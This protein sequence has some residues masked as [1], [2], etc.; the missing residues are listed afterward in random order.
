MAPPGLAGGA[1]GKDGLDEY[2]QRGFFAGNT[3]D[4]VI[5]FLD[6]LNRLT[7]HSFSFS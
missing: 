1:V 5:P 6:M 2:V 3:G 7:R 4:Q